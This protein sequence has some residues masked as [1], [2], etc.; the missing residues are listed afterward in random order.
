M[1]DYDWVPHHGAHK[2]VNDGREMLHLPPLEDRWKYAVGSNDNVP[3][4][5]HPARTWFTP[6]Q[7][8]RIRNINALVDHFHGKSK[9]NGWW[10]ASM[11]DN[12]L[13][14]SNKLALI[15]SEISEAMEGDRK[16][17]MD[18]KLPH[19]KMIEVELADALIRICDLAGFLNLDLG[20]AAVEKDAYNDNRADHKAEARS[21][22]GGKAY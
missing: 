13:V 19:R 3:V 11:R 6:K 18:D 5:E 7:S 10:P 21:A 14:V 1:T 15:H 8:D 2:A 12:Q 20:G 4:A 9:A 17:A 22:V 16:S